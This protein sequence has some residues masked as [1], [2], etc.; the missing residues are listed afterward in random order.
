MKKNKMIKVTS[1][2]PYG[3]FA[4]LDEEF[5]KKFLVDVTKYEGFK[6]VPEKLH[7]QYTFMEI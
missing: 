2:E 3:M 6:N 5:K 1:S 7:V 4:S